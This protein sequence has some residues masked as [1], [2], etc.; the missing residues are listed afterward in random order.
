[1]LTNE[2]YASNCFPTPNQAKINEYKKLIDSFVPSNT[3]GGTDTTVE[4][5]QQKIHELQKEDIERQRKINENYQKRYDLLISPINFEIDKLLIEIGNQNNTIILDAEKLDMKSQVLAFDDKIE[6]SSKV[7]P[8]LNA[9]FET[10]KKPDLQIVLPKSKVVKVDL[11]EVG[12]KIPNIQHF[13]VFLEEFGKKRRDKGTYIEN[14][15]SN[16]ILKSNNIEYKTIIISF[17]SFKSFA[18]KNDYSMILDSSIA[19]PEELQ[20]IP[21]EDVTNDFISYYNQ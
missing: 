5:L 8:L 9:Y 7:I 13:K 6:I 4:Y 10:N 16:A 1:M 18:Q 21:L 15:E 14:E 12:Q 3:I 11:A 2:F 19:L 17:A 20:N